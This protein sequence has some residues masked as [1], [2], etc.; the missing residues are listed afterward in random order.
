[1]CG[2]AG[3]VAW[4]GKI[5]NSIIR[6]MTDA[7]AHRGPDG[8]GHF[9]EE[10]VAIGHRRLAI[11]DLST[12]GHQ[13]MVS[14][15]E[16]FVLTYNGEIYNYKQLHQQL[17]KLGHRFRGSSDSEVLLNALIE[18]GPSALEQLE[19][20]FAFGL[21]DREQ[22]TLLLAR[23]RTGIKPLYV[24]EVNGLL[25]FASELKALLAT[26]IVP[27][28]ISG[29]AFHTYLASGYVDP[30]TSIVEGVRQVLPGTFVMANR[31]KISTSRYWEPKR[32]GLIRNPNEAQA[33]LLDK[34]RGAVA[35][36]TVS[37]V[38]IGLTL[39]SGIDSAIIA[40][41][42][43][44][45]R[46]LALTVKFDDPS[47]D[48]SGVARRV[49]EVAGHQWKA[50]QTDPDTLIE[51]FHAIALAS[52]G[53]LADSSAIAHYSLCRA[54]RS[55]VKV[56]LAG[57][58]ADEFFGGYPTISASLVA[59]KIGRMVPARLARSLASQIFSWSAN[60]ERRMTAKIVLARFLSGLSAR[61]QAHH[62]EWRRLSP[63]LNVCRLYGP[64][65]KQQVEVDPLLAYA[66]RYRQA[67][68]SV[69]D[70][71]LIA[72][73][74]HYLPGDMLTKVDRMSM[75]HGL[76]IRVPFIEHSIVELAGNIHASLLAPIFGP[77]KKILRDIAV[78]LGLP[79][80]IAKMRKH[81]FNVP[82]A[83][84]LRDQLQ[85]LGVQFLEEN[86]DIFAPHLDAD[87]VRE[88]WRSH[89]SRSSDHGYLIW[90]LLIHAVWR[91]RHT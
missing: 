47:F 19:G 82:V 30:G 75:A 51:D 84:L 15:D 17:T 86:P 26:G 42:L 12:T 16:R 58:G 61:R 43:K 68:G 65:L 10:G 6:S 85:P 8:E 22:K 20:M 45:R 77:K 53:E 34:L 13:P 1:M 69:V 80:D 67:S 7:I 91:E 24:I 3:V 29:S 81:G 59:N 90:A 79:S 23:D 83:N 71:A 87:S 44:E 37:D 72:D 52:D 73:Q 21:W 88:I 35:A 62:V 9:V 40:L 56:A 60:D 74:S 49:A 27:L 39:S 78:T 54:L 70:R 14:L 31:E 57:D 41:I 89:L 5:R 50:V 48:E 46:H 32:T 25:L 2:I 28:R 11:L 33:Q 63:E 64:A 36:T 4:D 66:E 18:W 76:E 55:Q 38:P